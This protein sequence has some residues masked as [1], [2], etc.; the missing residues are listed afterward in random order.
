MEKTLKESIG[1]IILIALL[2][3]VSTLYIN[4]LLTHGNASDDIK[5][6]E[7]EI[8]KRDSIIES[9]ININDSI[10]KSNTAIVHQVDSL[11][12]LKHAV[13]ITITKQVSATPDEA[14]KE[15]IKELNKYRNDKND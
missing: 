8:H 6:K 4:T 12:L 5:L 10:S 7:K 13:Y 2:I 1:T 3:V 14:F 9:Y 15:M 11:K